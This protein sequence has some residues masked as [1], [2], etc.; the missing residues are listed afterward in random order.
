MA[1]RRSNAPGSNVPAADSKELMRP[2]VKRFETKRHK[3]VYDVNTCRIVRVLPEVWDVIDDLGLLSERDIIAK[4]VSHYPAPQ[5]VAAIHAIRAAQKTQGIFLPNQVREIR[6]GRS[7]ERICEQLDKREAILILE[8]TEACT[9]R[10]TYCTFGGSYNHRRSHGSRA[11]RWEV[12][13]A[14]I[15]SRLGHVGKR[16]DDPPTVSFYGGE[17]LLNFGLIRE[18]VGYVRDALGRED[19]KFA[20]TT[21]AT[22]LKGE[23]AD[24]LAANDFGIT[25][26]LHVPPHIQDRDR[27]FCDGTGSWEV[28]W[29]NLKDFFNRHP[30]F[31]RKV[32]VNSVLVPPLDLREVQ[33][34]WD[35]NPLVGRFAGLLVQ[36]VSREDLAGELKILV[37]REEV[38]GWGD[39][40]RAFLHNLQGNAF[41]S[42]SGGR[43][44]LFLQRGL[45]MRPF[46]RFYNRGLAGPAAP[47]LPPTFCPCRTCIPGNTRLFVT[48]SGDYFPC[49]RCDM[50]SDSLR[51]GSVWTGL[52]ASKVRAIMA[53]YVGLSS[54]ECLSCWCLSYCS[55]GCPAAI[56]ERGQ[57]SLK[58]K[59][60]ICAT[61]RLETLR[62]MKDLSEVLEENPNALD[63][64]KFE[65]GEH[66]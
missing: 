53:T 37:G 31:D 59:R 17:P 16:R 56:Q 64:A 36:P 45:F 58:L 48:V 26:S 14:A 51:I 40:Y 23:A 6:L 25:V 15:D 41:N 60:E 27:P 47:S 63:F 65:D 10:C 34:F 32:V 43:G 33:R 61:H 50:M 57:L 22:L 52:D 49:E 62:T 7:Q 3:Y 28:V 20:L 2:L 29:S 46:S 66:T 21:N 19:V 5:V 13:R 39:L 1:G 18:T 54:D 9:L 24:F 55:S 44:D 42:D 4:H 30:A 8:V 11:M 12:A 35:G 38:T